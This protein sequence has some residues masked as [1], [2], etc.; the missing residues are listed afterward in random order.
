[1]VEHFL[2]IVTDLNKETWATFEGHH[3]STGSTKYFLSIPAHPYPNIFTS[4][5]NKTSQNQALIHNIYT[6][7]ERLEADLT[8]DAKE[9]QI[10]GI[11]TKLW[12]FFILEQSSEITKNIEIKVGSQ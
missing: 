1:M 2:N 9:L 7:R 8:K 6:I 10:N 11:T 5:Q 12:F 3:M 4:T